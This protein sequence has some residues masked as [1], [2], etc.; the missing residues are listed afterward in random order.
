M[1]VFSR[2]NALIY[3][4]PQE[5]LVMNSSAFDEKAKTVRLQVEGMT[6][7]SCELL[8]ERSW[9]NLP[10]VLSVKANAANHSVDLKCTADIPL[11]KLQGSL[12]DQKYTVKTAAEKLSAGMVPMKTHEMFGLF[13]LAI[14][15]AWI[16]G[17]LGG[18]T[19]LVPGN[20]VGMGWAFVLGILA[21][22]SSCLAVVSGLLIAVVAPAAERT[23]WKKRLMPLVSFL[24]GRLIAYA[25]LGG[26]L[27]WLG[28]KLSISPVVTAVMLVLAAV[29]M[30]IMGL[31]L[32]KML[33]QGLKKYLPH[34]PKVLAHGAVDKASAAGLL[35]PPL[36]GAATFFLPCGF[37]QALQA[38]A[39][40]TGSFGAG[41]AVLGAFALGSVPGLFALGMA[42]GWGKG[43]LGLW[44][45][46]FAGALVIV[47]GV[48]S[49]RSGLVLA[50]VVA[51]G[52]GAPA[53][54][55]GGE[56]VGQEQVIRM[57]V[58]ARG[59]EPNTFTVKAGQTVRWE[60]EGKP[61]A[62]CAMGIVS[63]SLG[64][65]KYLNPGKN[66]VKFFVPEPGRYSFACPMGMYSGQIIVE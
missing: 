42:V 13:A 24:G 21:S 53:A 35:M 41:A 14:G 17:Q 20:A 33:P 61:G 58:T 29:Y 30:V 26:L 18:G 49:I 25:V 6:C 39:L 9:K 32:L 56:S 47:L 45:N 65:E 4:H 5:R 55:V 12:L 36:L 15:L 60:I 59:Y 51:D 31:D 16:L 52:Q 10:G 7:N 62:G 64:L 57:D 3:L 22:F 2:V 27:G 11:E 66:V 19:S 48:I 23:T 28:A 8:V 40:T 34:T 1:R 63:P 50:S 54:V 38:Y 37:T 46:R 44:L 43:K